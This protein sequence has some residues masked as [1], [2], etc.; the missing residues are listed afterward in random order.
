M[1]EI[2]IQETITTTTT[3]T[4]SPAPGNGWYSVQDPDKP[5]VCLCLNDGNEGLFDPIP[6]LYATESECMNSECPLPPI[7]C[8]MTISSAQLISCKD[9]VAKFLIETENPEYDAVIQMKIGDGVWNDVQK[10]NGSSANV[11]IPLPSA[12]N[13]V[14]F[15]LYRYICEDQRCFI[16]W[17]NIAWDQPPPNNPRV[18]LTAIGYE[19]GDLM[20][21]ENLKYKYVPPY[22]I[23][24]P[25]G[26][27]TL[28][29]GDFGEVHGGTISSDSTR[30]P[31]VGEIVKVEPEE[32]DSSTVGAVYRIIK[33]ENLES[34]EN[35]VIT[36]ECANYLCDDVKQNMVG[37]TLET[38]YVHR[39][40]QEDCIL[41]E[42]QEPTIIKVKVGDVKNRGQRILFD[43]KYE[44]PFFL[45][46]GAYYRFDLSDSSNAND[47][48][49]FSVNTDGRDSSGNIIGEITSPGVVVNGTPGSD[50]AY[51]D[52]FTKTLSEDSVPF[53]AFKPDNETQE[54]YFFSKNNPNRG[55]TITM[56]TK[57]GADGGDEDSDDGSSIPSAPCGGGHVC[58]RAKFDIL[59]NGVLVLESNLNN[60]D[61]DT[62]KPSSKF[63][64]N[65]SPLP[66]GIGEHVLDRRCVTKI[67]EE[68]NAQIFAS[69]GGSDS[70]SDGGGLCSCGGE[71][72]PTA[73]FEFSIIPHESNKNP[74]FGVTWVRLKNRCGQTVYSC[75]I[76]LSFCPDCP[77]P[78]DC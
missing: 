41:T 4:S 57:S 48:L 10:Y 19:G 60:L 76:G 3:T 38:I 17:P 66:S 2:R 32:G 63:G 21:I 46:R 77:P 53:I 64:G 67:T 69:A 68:Q 33:I 13:T 43:D 37:W 50:G 25:G 59:I 73:P 40:V 6:I 29:L 7:V 42:G 54:F 24:G 75:C 5:S 30:D 71:E 49:S 61:D 70:D 36:L 9:G 22:Y 78:Q 51:I 15:R 27:P 47:N 20:K 26:T 58:D 39:F 31:V 52:V 23:P 34:D 35:R 28:P 44:T 55:G 62:S 14:H 12:D 72:E 56:A 65:W 18:V 11:E 45:T 1:T 16:S 74:H 8:E